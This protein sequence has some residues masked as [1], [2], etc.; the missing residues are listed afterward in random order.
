MRSRSICSFLFF[1]LLS[2][3]SLFSQTPLKERG[4]LDSLL[5]TG[6][7]FLETERP[8][9][10]R[11]AFQIVLSRHWK[12]LL[13]QFGIIQAD[14]MKEDWSS[15][16]KVCDDILH[17]D[18]QNLLAH[19][20]AGICRRELGYFKNATSHFQAI[21]ERDSLY[22]DVLYQCALVREYDGD[23]DGAIEWG[24][25]QVRKHPDSVGAQIGLFRIFRHALFQTDFGDALS[26]LRA[27]TDNY[28]EHAIGEL[29]RRHKRYSEAV[30]IF[31][32][33]LKEKDFPSQASCLSLALTYVQM[34]E[35]SAAAAV[36]WE[37]VNTI[38]NKVD[39]AIIFE[40]LKYIISDHELDE[41]RRA[42]TPTAMQEWFRRFWEIRNPV[43]TSPFNMRLIEHLQRFARAEKEFEYFG[44]R[45][46]YRNRDQLIRARLPRTFKLNREFNDKGLIYLRQ[47]PPDAVQ[48]R[49]RQG[50]P[51]TIQP[52]VVQFDA[53][54]SWLYSKSGST[55]GKVFN[56]VCYNGGQNY[57]ALVTLPLDEGMS[58]QLRVWD[59]RYSELGNPQTEAELESYQSETAVAALKS[60]RPAWGTDIKVLPIP[61]S[62][63]AFRAADGKTLLDI[64]YAIPVD[65]AADMMP[66]SGGVMP[67]EVGVSFL[68]LTGKEN[69]S[70]VDSL[71][72][73]VSRDSRGSYISLYRNAL[74]PDSVRIAMSV[75]AMGNE[76][77]GTWDEFLKVPDYS[78]RDFSLSD[79]QL[80]IPS[81]LPSSIEIEGVKVVQSPFGVYRRSSVFYTYLQMY[82]LVKDADGKTRYTAQ[83]S[84]V[85]R[86]PAKAD[87]TVSLGDITR[88][89]SEETF[90]DFHPLDLSGVEPGRYRLTV[91][92]TDRKRMETLVRARDI[93]VIP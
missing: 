11:A 60:D 14:M 26:Q 20:Y 85:P 7:Q 84:L 71:F 5:V 41:Y 33:L 90:A 64:S 1:A 4:F 19:Y 15:A 78:G 56:F 44:N 93:D 35:D 82:N 31:R 80:L 57:W 77:V 18:R 46:R 54:E 10:A 61:H 22:R 68:S 66:D 43:P 79:L 74:V 91:S 12:P 16:V 25:R 63:S 21:L 67:I 30:D 70:R 6:R 51:E 36:Y 42:T 24:L 48:Q 62:I 3:S 37:G 8:D 39:A 69:I 73:S 55:V 40:N 27:R 28:S 87:E 92:I 52:E 2:P 13:A 47:G 53:H 72:L 38:T 45:S 50:V 65:Q 32:N 49:P 23:F 76:L 81:T 29:L 59:I 58:S 88:D 9:S 83:Y 75:R 17:D 34:G 89:L 86:D